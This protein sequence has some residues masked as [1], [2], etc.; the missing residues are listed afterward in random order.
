MTK[1]HP[2]AAEDIWWDDENENE[3]RAHRIEAADVEDVWQEVVVWA[4]NK[5]HRAGDWKMIGRSAAG[6][7]L[8]IVVRYY[9]DR[10]VLRPITGWDCTPGEI[11]RYFK[12]GRS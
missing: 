12:G 7:R 10:R 6:R 1:D 8:T 4:R 11:T 5:R 2:S 9:S 3:L